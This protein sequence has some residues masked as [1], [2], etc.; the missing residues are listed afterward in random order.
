[1][2]ELEH[3]AAGISVPTTWRDGTVSAWV[4]S[5]TCARDFSLSPS[6]VRATEQA[7]AA[8]RESDARIPEA[9]EA[10]ARLLLRHEGVASSG[11]EGLREPLVSVLIAERTG[12]GG[13]AGWVADNLAVIHM[14]LD[15][16]DDTLDT[17]T[18]DRWHERLMRNSDLAPHLIGA[19]RPSVG[20]VGG[21]SPLDAAYVP[22]PPER[23][24]E[25][26]DDL[27]RFADGAG[28]G[29]DPITHAAVLHAQFELIHPYGDGNG[30][31]GR[32]LI[33]RALR[34]A[35]LTVRST[36]PISV[37]IA[38]DPGGYLSGL[39]L[40]ELGQIGPWVE[41]FCGVVRK[42][43]EA[44]R[45][46]AERTEQTAGEWN[47]RLGGV[48]SDS[49]ARALV[50]LLPGNPVVSAQD[51]KLLLGVSQP[52]ARAALLTLAE[53]GIV[54][55]VQTSSPGAGRNRN[56]FAATDLLSTWS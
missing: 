11:I 30:R 50:P 27:V 22:P 3:G 51:V 13:A 39:K 28:T 9:W 53:R 25:L 17:Q 12:A 36:A 43:A 23:I 40:Y 4:P 34:R 19:F 38:R 41:W 49:A 29:L 56:W 7:A 44:T 1:M 32:I 14:A 42:A 8:L 16:A 46:L 54:A 31:L 55:P 20:W 2:G 26:M 45:H 35:K 21:N 33:S 24:A 5:K 47:R 48:R 37:A 10:L 6:Q 18:L 15:A 52:A